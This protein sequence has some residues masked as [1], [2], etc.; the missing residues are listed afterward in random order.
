MGIVSRSSGGANWIVTV[1][2]P[3]ASVTTY[4][5]EMPVEHADANRLSKIGQRF[6]PKLLSIPSW[7]SSCAAGLAACT[8]WHTSVEVAVVTFPSRLKPIC[9][10][11]SAAGESPKFTRVIASETWRRADVGGAP[12]GSASTSGPASAAVLVARCPEQDAIAE[13]AAH[14]ATA[15]AARF[16]TRIELLHRPARGAAVQGSA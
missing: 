3:D 11:A 13:T 6:C 9:F 15:K 14:A 12:T 16:G 4:V 2:E 5:W 7:P 10:H 1:P 8:S